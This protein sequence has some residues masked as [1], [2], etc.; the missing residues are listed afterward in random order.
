MKHIKI[1][2]THIRRAPYQAIAAI[3]ICAITF[4]LASVFAVVA[5][6]SSAILRYFETR[7]QVTVFFKDETTPSQVSDLEAKVKA[8]GLATDIKYVS[9][10]EA[11]AI[12]REQNKNDPLLLEMVTASILPASL[13]IQARDP[14]ALKQIAD[15][16]S[17]DPTVEEVLFQED[18][19][20]ALISWTKFIRIV[21]I[22]FVSTFVVLSLV[23]ILVIIGMKIAT[24]KDE[25]EILYL[26][27]ATNW[28]IRAPF[29][30]EGLFYGLTGAVF[31]WLATLI[32]LLYSTP[33]LVTFLAGLPLLPIPLWFYSALLVGT[34]LAGL[35]LGA[36]GSLL[37]VRRYLKA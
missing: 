32:V 16:V 17:S 25:I 26:I 1:A 10:E 7:P 19:V 11:L 18:I 30:F 12:Y 37:A 9:K 8:S 3:G 20:A 22:S 15:Q 27:G 24:K 29:L 21:G 13:E 23:I 5:V 31:A 2:L 36:I 28:Y 6:G 34:L 14:Q 33:F 4:F 35:I